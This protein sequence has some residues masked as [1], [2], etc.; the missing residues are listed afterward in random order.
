M[1]SQSQT[2][3]NDKDNVIRRNRRQIIKMAS[4]LVKIE[5]DNNMD[6]DTET[7]PIARRSISAT[8]LGKLSRYGEYRT[9]KILLIKGGCYV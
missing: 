7:E 3:L 1:T 5:N 4:K 8:K 6:N 2:L 9:V